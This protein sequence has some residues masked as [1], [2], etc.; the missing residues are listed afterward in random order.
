MPIQFLAGNIS[1]NI[2]KTVRT[3]SN[4]KNCVDSCCQWEE[5]HIAIQSNSTCLNVSFALLLV[6]N[7]SVYRFNAFDTLFSRYT[8]K[9]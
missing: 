8:V 9:I 4:I 1:S 5:C 3:E 7:I 2:K 6:T